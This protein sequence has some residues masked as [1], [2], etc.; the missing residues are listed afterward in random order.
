MMKNINIKQIIDK[1]ILNPYSKGNTSATNMFTE[2]ISKPTS[3]T[4][5]NLHS[6]HLIERETGIID[7][8]DFMFIDGILLKWFLE[9]SK[10]IK[11]KRVSFDMTSLAKH[12][13][14]FASKSKKTIYILGE[15]KNDIE[16]AIENILAEYQD[17]DIV[18]F[19]SG[20]F[21]NKTEEYNTIL[22]IV[23]KAPQIIIVGMGTPRQEHFL[24]SLQKEGWNGLGFTCGA[25]IKQTAKSLNYYP[26]V[27]NKFH[28]RWLYRIFDEPKLFGRYF[29]EYPK[30]LQELILFKLRYDKDSD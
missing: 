15:T 3:I 27:F 21:K 6:L 24:I 25:F 5:I 7:K 17:L 26:K 22:E 20:Y 8:L 9:K 4:F 16:I 23:S 10:S 1:L 14:D 12:L 11:L 30:V 19:H 18:G 2:M 29:F 28:L 13:F